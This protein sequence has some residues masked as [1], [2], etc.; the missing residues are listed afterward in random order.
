MKIDRAFHPQLDLDRYGFESA[1]TGRGL[2]SQLEPKPEEFE[3]TKT[4][5]GA[6]IRTLNPFGDGF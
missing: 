3:Y 5:R 4:G 1:I 2:V 6:G